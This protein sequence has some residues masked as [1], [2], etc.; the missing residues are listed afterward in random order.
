[1]D[2]SDSVCIFCGNKL[3][4][5]IALIE[6]GLES[7][8]QASLRVKDGL[9]ERLREKTKITVQ[10]SFRQKYTRPSSIWASIKQKET[11][12]S[13]PTKSS[14]S[15]S[16]KEKFDFKNDCFIC[17]KPAVVDSKY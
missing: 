16:S 1:M 2:D 11:Y 10:K 3:E 5:E 12:E 9:H 13:A 17:G 14:F 15:R 4:N 6:K 8:I 7:I